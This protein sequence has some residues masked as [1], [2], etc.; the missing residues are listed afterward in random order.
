MK[1]AIFA[2]SFDPITLGHLNLIERA[3]RLFD[4][5]ILVIAV[6]P[7][8][9]TLFSLQERQKMVKKAIQ[10]L[11]HVS[12][13]VIENQLLV[14]YAQ[15]VGARYIIRGIRT[16]ADFEYEQAMFAINQSQAKEIETLFLMADPTYRFVSSSVVKE[17][18]AYGGDLSEMVLP[19]IAQA[20]KDKFK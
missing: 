8:K 7:S 11:D 6:N 1:K 18:A 20:L 14:Q 3:T 2:G 19:H 12:L 15:Q 13:E 16:V 4:Q 9:Q 10:G 17:I 5:L